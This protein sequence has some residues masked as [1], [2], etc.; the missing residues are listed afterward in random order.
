[1]PAPRKRALLEEPTVLLGHG[2][3]S[4]RAAESVAP[5]LAGPA[6]HRALLNAAA[7]RDCRVQPGFPGPGRASSALGVQGR[8]Q[9]SADTGMNPP[10][11]S[12]LV[13]K[14]LLSPRTA[15]PWRTC[16]AEL[17]INSRTF[18][19]PNTPVFIPRL[20]G[21]FPVGTSAHRC[22][23]A[24]PGRAPGGSVGSRPGSPPALGLGVPLERAERS[25]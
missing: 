25:P 11:Y 24:R 16:P 4:P 5:G 22:P 18:W 13:Q 2:A 23:A 7:I 12:I 21:L 8:F 10:V 6:T 19:R 1:M 15:F 20:R 14:Q 17:P 9:T 3:G